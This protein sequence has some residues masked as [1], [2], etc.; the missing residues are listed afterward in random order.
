MLH[1][2][3][4]LCRKFYKLGNLLCIFTY[5]KQVDTSG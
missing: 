2:I 1:M 3:N 4:F 5:D